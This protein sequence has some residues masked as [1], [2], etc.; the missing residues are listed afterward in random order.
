M[1]NKD[2]IKLM[3]NIFTLLVSLILSVFFLEL[4]YRFYMFGWDSLSIEKMNSVH[5]IGKSGLI[6]TS[7]YSEII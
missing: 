3:L 4:A 7:Q 6:K 1:K 5:N 2:I